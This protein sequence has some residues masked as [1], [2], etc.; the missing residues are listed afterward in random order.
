MIVQ[1]LIKSMIHFSDSWAAPDYDLP[2]IAGH[3]SPPQF[4]NLN[5]KRSS[6]VDVG[7]A[8]FYSEVGK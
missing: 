5:F 8:Q 7:Q 3:S 6:S 4:S 2:S 1:C